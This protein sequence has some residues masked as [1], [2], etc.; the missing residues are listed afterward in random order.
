LGILS[1]RDE[2]SRLFWLV[3]HGFTTKAMSMN[4]SETYTVSGNNVDFINRNQWWAITSSR[5]H[6]DNPY[7]A[8]VTPISH[9]SS[10]GS[11]LRSFSMR[12]A[13]GLFPGGLWVFGT[14]ENSTVVRY[15]RFNTNRSR[16]SITTTA[17]GLL[18]PDSFI[19]ELE[20]AVH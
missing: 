8:T 20:L 12:N 1:E 19:T 9:V 2:V 18:N 15:N 4:L 10:A 14:R 6:W 7:T 11:Q 16:F 13:D 5:P 17:S 3:E